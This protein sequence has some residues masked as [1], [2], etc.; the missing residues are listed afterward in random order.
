MGDDKKPDSTNEAD[1]KDSSETKGD[2]KSPGSASGAAPADDVII[3][4]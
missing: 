4:K 2:N 3:I 1:E